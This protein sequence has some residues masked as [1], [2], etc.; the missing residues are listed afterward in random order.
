MTLH[1][2]NQSWK[3]AIEPGERNISN[4]I[5]V[6]YNRGIHLQQYNLYLMYNCPSPFIWVP[7]NK[8]NGVSL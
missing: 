4:T 6:H 8:E 5:S 2:L 3:M 7:Y 1:C